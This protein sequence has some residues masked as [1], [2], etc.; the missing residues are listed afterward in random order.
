MVRSKWNNGTLDIASFQ[1]T[2]SIKY[3]LT[4]TEIISRCLCKGCRKWRE[5]SIKNLLQNKLKKDSKIK[6]KKIY[7]WRWRDIKKLCITEIVVLGSGAKGKDH[8]TVS[9]LPL[10]LKKGEFTI[11]FNL[12][13]IIQKKGNSQLT[14]RLKILF[15]QFM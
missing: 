2:K 5:R 1:E 10:S 4:K 8:S 11:S 14:I 7:H 9:L 13:I 12:Q 6:L 3:K 15:F